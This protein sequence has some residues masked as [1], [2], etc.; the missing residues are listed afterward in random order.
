M[1]NNGK[2]A[3]IQDVAEKAGVSLATVSRVF[4]RKSNVALETKERVLEEASRL[5]YS[6]RKYTRQNK[7]TAQKHVA[8]LLSE[9]LDDPIGGQFYGLAIRS[10]ERVLGDLEYRLFFR[11]VRGDD[12]EPDLAFLRNTLDDKD[13][14]GLVLVGCPMSEKIITALKE[15]RIPFVLLDNCTPH[16]AVDCV[17]NDNVFGAKAVVNHLI[18]LGH[19]RIAFICE[20]VNHWSF[21]ERFHG[22]ELALSNAGIEID[23]D[24]IK[25]GQ[26]H[27][28]RYPYYCTCELFSDPDKAPSAIFAANDTMAMDCVKALRDMGLRVPQDVSI[29]GYDDMYFSEHTEP[30]LTTIRVFRE[31]M[32]EWAAR[33][34]LDRI[35]GNRLRPCRLVLSVEMVV[36]DSSAKRQVAPSKS[37]ESKVMEGNE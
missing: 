27:H 36:R 21:M 9:R 15:Q 22:Y 20:T 17:V 34:L 12:Q 18:E 14:A 4:N 16:Q 25:T 3:T 23:K 24:L 7:S 30:G 37:M 26:D 19:E 32:G 28:R 8:V 1:D 10:L 29:V 35:N 33:L 5:G 13:L 6:P 31:D 2:G 11:T